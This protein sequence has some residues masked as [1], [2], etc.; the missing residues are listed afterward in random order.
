MVII[1]LIRRPLK[2]VRVEKRYRY[3]SRENSVGKSI[4]L[5]FIRASGV[6][7]ELATI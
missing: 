6:A 4:N 5:L 2:K 7:K 1:R 3:A